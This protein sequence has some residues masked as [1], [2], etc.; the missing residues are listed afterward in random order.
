MFARL[1][2]KILGRAHLIGFV[3]LFPFDFEV[4]VDYPVHVD[5]FGRQ[6][7]VEVGHRLVA[8][9]FD[10]L[11]HDAVFHL[12]FA[13]LEAALQQFLAILGILVLLLVESLLDFYPTLRGG[14]DVEPVLLGSLVGRGEYL[15]GVAAFEFVFDGFDFPVHA[16]AHAFAAQPGVNEEGKVEQGGPQRQLVQVALGGEDKHLLVV[17]VHLEVAHQLQGSAVFGRFEHLAHVVHPVVESRLALDALVFP[18]GCQSAFGNLVHTAGAYLHLDPA[19]TGPQHGDV[20]RLIPVRLGNGEPVFHSLGVG[21]VHVGDNRV[22]LPAVGLLLVER[23]LQNHPNGK[24]VVDVFQVGLLFFHLVP[25]GKNRLGAPLDFKVQT[26]GFEFPFDRLDKFGDVFVAASFRLVEL[27]GYLVVD[28][29]VGIF[30]RE[31]FE[32][33]FDGVEPQP[34]GQRRVEVRRLASHVVAVFFV[35]V[36]VDHLHHAQAV[37]NHDDDDPNVFGKRE[38]QF[39][40]VLTLDG[41]LLGIEAVRLDKA[42]N[43]VGNVVAKLLLHGFD[44]EKLAHDQ[45]EN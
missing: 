35:G 6:F 2:G 30:E 31:V 24:E 18:V 28:L 25:D 1:Q 17:E 44:G 45:I 43:D 36:M 4:E 33:R 8:H 34:V 12:H 19:L 22:D 38:Q 29:A 20:Q 11:H 15:D 40:K 21:L 7:I 26:F 42:P 5:V 9:F 23:S 16:A 13:V 10:E 27:V 39:A 14:G 3:V 41:R 37:G 32:F